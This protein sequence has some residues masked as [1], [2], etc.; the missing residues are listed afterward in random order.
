[1]DFLKRIFTILFKSGKDNSESKSLTGVVVKSSAISFVAKALTLIAGLVTMPIVYNSLDKYQFGVYATLTSIISWVDLFDFGITQGLRNR[2]T[3]ARADG[4]INAARKYISTSYILLFLIAI[5]LFVLYCL[6]CRVINWQTILNAKELDRGLLDSMAFWVFSLFLVRFVA[7]VITKVYYAFQKS[8]LVDVTILIG[9]IAYLIV[10]LLLSSLGRITLFN[11]A[12]LQSSISAIIPIL[13]SIYFFLIDEKPYRPSIRMVDFKVTGHIMGLGWQFFIISISLLI[14]HSGNNFLISQF[15][16]PA[17]VP[18]YSLSYQLLSYILLIYTIIITP[19]WS[20]Y[21]EAWK[22]NDIE[23]I[24]QT[25]RMMKRIFMLFVVVCAI[26]VAFTPYIFRVWIGEKADV[27][28]LM[29][30]AVAIM[31]LLD[32]WIRIFDFFINGVG[33]IRVQM[34]VNIIMA[35]LNIPLAFLF[36]VICHMGAIGVVIAS[37]ISFGVSAVVSPLQANMLL[38]GTAKG[39]WAK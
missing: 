3:E 4:D 34:I 12:I 1:M 19:L 39:V 11:V 29:A 18:A 31:I 26:V 24:C 28:I 13:A 14:I 23:W 38:N 7:S 6:F 8:Y 2:L 35:C 30:G 9:K 25:M 5:T 36:S 22:K 21:T 20:A 33:K 10:L 27:P 17:S 37:I 16:D 32:M 15:V